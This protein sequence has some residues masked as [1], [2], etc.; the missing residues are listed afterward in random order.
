MQLTL[1][2]SP[3]GNGDS[4]Y[5]FNRIF[6]H[7]VDVRTTGLDG[8][9]AFVLWGGVDI[10]P[11]LYNKQPHPFTQEN[12]KQ[13][14]RRDE[15]EWSTLHECVK[16]G[17]PIIG[18]C[19]GAQMLCA[20]A[21]GTL[22]QHV[23]GHGGWHG[24]QFRNGETCPTNS[25]HHQMM[26]PFEI[27]HDMIAWSSQP[28]SSVYEE[29][30]RGVTNQ[31]MEHYVEPEIVWFPKLKGLAIQGHPEGYSPPPEFV[32]KCCELVKEYVL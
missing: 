4:I 12:S 8:V 16:R 17:I 32:D 7:K 3:W 23:D 14:S 11:K 31:K 2:Y 13:L 18:V 20:A 25:L 26:Y 24:L 15:W 6:H 10:N 19:R 22:I 9:D 29:E 28:L 1:G 21:G 30:Y 27:E 5:P